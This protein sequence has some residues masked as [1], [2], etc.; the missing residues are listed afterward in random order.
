M[1]QPEKRKVYALF[2]GINNYRTDLVINGVYFPQLSG[3]VNDASSLH[4][5]LLKDKSLDLHALSLHNSEATKTAIVAAFRQHLSIAKATDAVLIYYS[6]HGTTEAA[7]PAIWHEEADGRLEAIVCHYDHTH[8]PGFLLTDKELR[9]LLHELY[10]KTGAHIV[11]IFDCCHSGDN[12]RALAEPDIVEKRVDTVF[13]QRQ[14][15][16]FLFS[17]QTGKNELLTKSLSEVLPQGAHVQLAASESDE[18]AVEYRGRGAFTRY[19]LD[20][21]RFSQGR[22]SYRDL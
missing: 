6:G 18:P 4:A 16:E 11:T 17:G 9:F 3:C 7:D 5:F 1:P 19:L 20:A 13:P 22:I 14:W 2:I 21:L 10:E 12:T 15:E 8:S